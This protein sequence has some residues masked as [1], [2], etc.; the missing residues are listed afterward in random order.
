MGETTEAAPWTR[1][2]R[3][4]RRLQVL[5]AAQITPGM[6]RVTLG[7][8]ELAGIADGCNIKLLFPRDADTP[9]CLPLKGPD[10]RALYAP[11]EVPPVI[12]TY[13]VRTHDREAGELH[14]DFVMHG[15]GVASEWARRAQP[16]DPIGMAGP[17]GLTLRPSDAYVIAGDQTALPAISSMLEKLPADARGHAFIEIPDPAERQP[18]LHP[19]GIAVTWLIGRGEPSPLIEA[20]QS[21]PWPEGKVFAWIGAESLPTRVL[22]AYVREGRGLDRRQHLAIGYWKRGMSETEYK[23]RHDNDRD[24]DYHATARETPGW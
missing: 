14:V 17:G 12:R 23:T 20:V 16:G 1:R 21:V 22:R 3:N 5:R 24:A 9:L 4:I 2:F 15:H 10:G 11:G 7:G 18:L 19:P 8:E 6:R 13:S